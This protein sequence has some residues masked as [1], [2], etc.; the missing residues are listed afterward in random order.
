MI[1]VWVWGHEPPPG[2][3][4]SSHVGCL[5]LFLLLILTLHGRSH[6][7]LFTS[8]KTESQT[9][10]G[11]LLKVVLLGSRDSRTC[12]TWVS[13]IYHITLL[14]GSM[15]WALT[16]VSLTLERHVPIISFRMGNRVLSLGSCSSLPFFQL[17]S[18]SAPLVTY[19]KS[20][21]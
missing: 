10:V 18:T 16:H 20:S 9:E 19:E 6:W 5:L 14:P 2:Y 17:S 15:S 4:A 11:G 3:L 8:E 13:H 12:L 21:S 1:L 7:P